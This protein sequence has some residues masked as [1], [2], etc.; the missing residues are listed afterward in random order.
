[1]AENKLDFSNGIE[2]DFKVTVWERIHVGPD[3]A[4]KVYDLVNKGKINT[5]NDIYNIKDIDTGELNSEIL[6]ETQEQMSLDDNDNQST[7]EILCEGN[8]IY[9][10]AKNY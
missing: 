4:K 6:Y 8:T 10:N 3:I 7:I 5:V 2:I 1:M 9:S